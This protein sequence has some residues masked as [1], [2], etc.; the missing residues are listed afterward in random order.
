M[1]KLGIQIWYKYY[2][3]WIIPFEIANTSATFQN[4][5][6]KIMLDLIDLSVFVYI[7]DILIYSIE[8]NEY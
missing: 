4:M 5:M 1:S 7:N 8:L 6:N 3:S 2:K